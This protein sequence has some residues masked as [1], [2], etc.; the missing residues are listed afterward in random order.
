[1]NRATIL[2]MGL[3]VP[4]EIRRN[5]AWPPSFLEAFEQSRA[6]RAQRDFTAFAAKSETRPFDHLFAKHAIPHES[7]PFKGATE[8]RVSSDDEETAECDARAARLAF[9]DARI[10]PRDVDLVLSSA[11]VPDRLTPSNGPR[12]QHL[13][14]CSGAAGIGV[15]AVCSSALAQLELA[16]GLVEAGRARYVLCVQSH[17]IARANDLSVPFSPLFGDGSGAFVVGQAPPDRGL[18][19]VVRDGDGSLAGGITFA[20]KQTP[21]ARWYRNAAGPVHPG[22]EDIAAARHVGE[23]LLGFAIE[24]IR[25]ICDKAQVPIDA[26]AAVASIQPAVWYQA[27][28]ADGLGISPERVPSTYARYAHLGAA[29]VVANLIEARSRGLLRDRAPVV[30]YAHGAGLTRYVALLRWA[31]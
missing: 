15:E 16:A 8:R 10:D 9:E 26:L 22:S 7:D 24:A 28:V 18:M 12:I 13:V 3:W 27:A 31:V 2:G 4:P 21:G 1:M 20:Y 14:G 17:H 5:D 19:R 6:A 29:G 11:L 30:L 25:G 23:N